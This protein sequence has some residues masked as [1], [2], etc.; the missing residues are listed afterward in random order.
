MESPV[1]TDLEGSLVEEL[2]NKV[3]APLIL[4][5]PSGDVLRFNKSCETLSGF[6][7]HEVAGR[8]FWELFAPSEDAEHVKTAIFDAQQA[9]ALFEF[10]GYWT[11]KDNGRVLIEWSLRPIIHEANSI[12]YIVA[13]GKDLTHRRSREAALQESQAFLRSIIDASPV[14]VIT[15]NEKGRILTF[16]RQAELTFGYREVDVLGKNIKMLMPEPDRSRHDQYISH[17]AE[18]GERRI[19][20][21]ARLIKALRQNGEVFPA[22]LHVSE[23]HN[24]ND[25]YVGFVEDVTERIDTERRLNETQE[26]LHHAGRLGAMGEIATSIAHELNQPLTAAAS[27]TGAVSLTLKKDNEERFLNTTEMLD[28]AI[29]EI[30]RASEIISNM[31]DFVRKRK[32]ARSIHDVNKVVEDA[33]KIALIGADADGIRVET[34]FDKRAGE[35]MLD[36]VQIQQVVTNLIRNAIDAMRAAPERRLSISTKRTDKCIE[37]SVEDTGVGLA[38]EIKDQLF[39]PFVSNKVDGTG[40][41]LSISKAIIDAHQG[42]I[43]AHNKVSGGCTFVFRLPIIS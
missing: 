20:G 30:K 35:M 5:S 29:G 18:T 27:L 11:V 28:D 6:A 24:D 25:I 36:R 15:I 23:F 16:S 12:S 19:I 3:D 8:K 14:A 32:T 37:V 13:S 2:L 40:I 38:D 33:S 26:Q 21:K 17:Y 39:Q 9:D 42:E 34:N 22:I 4:L 7:G 43:C 41:G 10:S 1:L 31:R